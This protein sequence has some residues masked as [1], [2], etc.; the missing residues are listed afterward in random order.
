M[1]FLFGASVDSLDSSGSAQVFEESMEVAK[2]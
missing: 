1:G 2:G